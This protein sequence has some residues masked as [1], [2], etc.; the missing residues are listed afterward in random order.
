M[1]QV[2]IEPQLIMPPRKRKQVTQNQ[3]AFGSD[4]EEFVEMDVD[5][6]E[7]DRRMEG[8]KGTGRKSTGAILDPEVGLYTP[9]DTFECD[10]HVRFTGTRKEGWRLMPSSALHRVQASFIKKGGYQQERYV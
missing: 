5:L 2:D 1:W 10:I 6:D 3:E 4:E 8:Q 7:A 9:I